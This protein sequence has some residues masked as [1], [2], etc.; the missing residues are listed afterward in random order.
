M[1]FG[2]T[3]MGF[4]AL[5]MYNILNINYNPLISMPWTTP[6][7]VTTFLQGGF[8]YMLIPLVL[9]PLNILI[10]YPFFRVADKRALSE[11]QSI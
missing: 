10:W 1:V 2:P 3:I 8:Q 7:L 6:S 4:V 9:I 11:E 5:F